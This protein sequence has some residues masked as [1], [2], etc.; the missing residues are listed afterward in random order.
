PGTLDAEPAAFERQLDIIQRHFEISSIDDLVRH[1]YGR[2]L[3][4]NP[5]LIT[6]DDAYRDNYDI[7]LPILRKR[8]VRAAFFIATAFPGAGQLYWW[9]RVAIFLRRARR[10]L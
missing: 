8:G 4:P 7:V 6:F 10:D 3:P 2:P 1:R 9:D 5:I